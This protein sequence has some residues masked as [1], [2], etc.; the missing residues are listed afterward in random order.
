MNDISYIDYAVRDYEE[1]LNAIIEKHKHWLEADCEDW[2]N[3]RA[4]LSYVVCNKLDFNGADLRG[5]DIRDAEFNN[6]NMDAADFTDAIFHNVRFINCSLNDSIFDQTALSGCSFLRS[7]AVCASFNKAHIQ[8]SGFDKMDLGRTSFAEALI[9]TTDFQ[10]VDLSMA[11]FYRASFRDTNMEKSNLRCTFEKADMSGLKFQSCNFEGIMLKDA[12]NV[13]Y[14][15]M[16]CPE[17][18][19][20][21]GYKKAIGGVIIELEIPG[22]AKRSSANGRKCR[23]NKAYVRAIYKRNNIGEWTEITEAR[24]KFDP[25]FVYKVGEMVKVDNFDEN[26]WNECAPGIHFFISKQEAIDYGRW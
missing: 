15:P 17:T 9:H 3:M 26:R 4:R 10:S 25:N 5:A 11:D 7:L 20:F 1:E 2:Q 16:T 21:I 8:E 23:C 12:I 24:S 13:P 18:G 19:S 22:D 14:I 6:C